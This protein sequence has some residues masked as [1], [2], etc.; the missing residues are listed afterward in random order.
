[1]V[2]AWVW[3]IFGHGRGSLHFSYTKKLDCIISLYVIVFLLLLLFLVFSSFRVYVSVRGRRLRQRPNRT[4]PLWICPNV[5]VCGEEDTQGRSAII[6]FQPQP[7][8]ER[9]HTNR[10]QCHEWTKNA[11]ISLFFV[12]PSVCGTRKVNLWLKVAVVM[13]LL[14]AAVAA[15][16]AAVAVIVCQ[17]ASARARAKEMRRGR[18]K[19]T[20]VAMESESERWAPAIE[21]IISW[22]SSSL[23]L[24]V[25]AVA[26]CVHL[27]KC[28][29]NLIK[30]LSQAVFENN[31]KKSKAQPEHSQPASLTKHTCN[32][33]EIKYWPAE[34]RAFTFTCADPINSVTSESHGYSQIKEYKETLCGR[35]RREKK[36]WK[37]TTFH[38]HRRNVRIHTG[39]TEHT[40]AEKEIR[41]LVDIFCSSRECIDH[42]WDTLWSLLLLFDSMYIF[43]YTSF[44]GL[45]LKCVAKCRTRLFVELFWPPKTADFRWRGKKK[46]ERERK[47]IWLNPD[48]FILTLYGCET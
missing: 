25:V 17:W 10:P 44:F 8:I 1:M 5:C 12:F 2:A 13:M 22:L 30:N 29:S 37:I 45:L 15:T 14:A 20:K 3:P 40:V 48:T 43:Y 39:E 47:P 38:K 36:K 31:K 21:T 28:M 23:V 46:R 24:I 33:I 34:R 7:A 16:S 18:G 6:P 41:Q 19:F 4:F 26:A 32:Q 11:G 35:Q 42:R 9:I 27:S